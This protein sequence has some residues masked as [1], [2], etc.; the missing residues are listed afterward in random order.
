MRRAGGGSFA[1]VRF[2]GFLA[3]LGAAADRFDRHRL[4][5]HLLGAVD[6][7]EAR[8]VR[9]LEGALHRGQGARRHHQRRV[10]AG[11]TNVRAH[12]DLDLARR[13]TLAGDFSSSPSLPSARH[14]A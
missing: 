1:R 10:G 5:H 9:L 4:D 6:E 14:R 11:I 12:E 3:E 2:A 7:A 8:L 13:H